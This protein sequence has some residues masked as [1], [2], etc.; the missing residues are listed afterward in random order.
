MLTETDVQQWLIKIGFAEY[1]ETFKG[2]LYNKRVLYTSL[3]ASIYGLFIWGIVIPVGEKTFRTFPY[4]N[5]MKSYL[6]PSNA[7]KSF[8][9][10]LD[11]PC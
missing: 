6:I 9:L 8:T 10:Y 5:R 3:Y 7:T 4:E 11:L 1:C 2:M